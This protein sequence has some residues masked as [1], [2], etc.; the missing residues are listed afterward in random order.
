MTSSLLNGRQWLKA[1]SSLKLTIVCLILSM[2]LVF[3]GTLA[4]VELGIYEAQ[5]RYFSTWF[6]WWGPDAAEGG[7]G[8]SRF[9][10]EAIWSAVY[11]SSICWL[12]M[13]PA[14]N[15]HGKNPVFS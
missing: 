2:I 15:G 4:Q 9:C 3:L 8:R 1:W 7:I 13:E 6:V 11:F 12:P 14:L 5:Q 10:P